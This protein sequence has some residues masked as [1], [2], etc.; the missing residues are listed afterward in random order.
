MRSGIGPSQHLTELGITTIADLPVGDRLRAIGSRRRLAASTER[1]A[2]VDDS[3][4][5]PADR[6][7]PL[8][9]AVPVEGPIKR[10]DAN[11]RSRITSCSSR[12]A[13]AKRPGMTDRKFVRLRT[14]GTRAN[15]NVDGDV[16]LRQSADRSA[17]SIPSGAAVRGS[18]RGSAADARWGASCDMTHTMRSRRTTSFRNERE[19]S[20]PMLTAISISSFSSASMVRVGG[21]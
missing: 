11:G 17:T 12:I 16:A 5:Q 4:A 19:C 15:G 18:A 21:G 7:I 10:L 6:G 1:F 3:R 14:Y 13:A 9:P 8:G 20:N 2:G